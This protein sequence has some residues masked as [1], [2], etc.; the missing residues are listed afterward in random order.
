MALVSCPECK[1]QVSTEAA[2]CPHCG[3]QL[4]GIAGAPSPSAGPGFFVPQ[5][6]TGPE[7]TLWEGRPSI[8]LLYGK[9]AR[10]FIR[11]IIVIVIGYF[12]FTS[13]LPAL[14]SVSSAASSFVEQNN[15]LLVVGI[16]VVLALVLLP[17]V[18]G[19]LQAW[20]RIKNTHYRI[21]NQ[22]IV[23]QSGV[24]S[25]SL[26]EIDMRSIDDIEFNQPLLE[27]L[28]GIGQIFIVSTD[29]VAPRLSL[30]GIHDPLKIRELIRS[31]AYQ[32]SQRQLFT[33]ST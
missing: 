27:R 16:L 19:L 32:V 1:Q 30:Q 9:L 24:L 4:S 10:F 22:R 8:A 31:N 33:R 6:A 29:K 15:T 18:M 12:V 7:E 21:T 5:G 25:R 13:G 20:A 26:E 3:K 14:A 28:F 2:S 17:S 11:L 23:I